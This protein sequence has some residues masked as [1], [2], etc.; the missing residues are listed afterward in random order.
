MW[1]NLV[2]GLLDTLVDGQYHAA[3]QISDLLEELE[4]HISDLLLSRGEQR[5]WL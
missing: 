3:G 5:P 2:P 1:A 4:E